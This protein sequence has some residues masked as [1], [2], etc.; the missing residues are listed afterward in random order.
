MVLIDVNVMVYAHR[1]ESPRHR[2]FRRWYEGQVESGEP[3]GVSDLV[4]DRKS[5]V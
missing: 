5:V 4:I 1:P 2:E 3:F